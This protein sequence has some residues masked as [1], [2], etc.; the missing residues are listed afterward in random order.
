MNNC[1]YCVLRFTFDLLYRNCEILTQFF[2]QLLSIIEQWVELVCAKKI[3]IY[4]LSYVL[5]FNP[6]FYRQ[7]KPLHFYFRNVECFWETDFHAS[8]E[9]CHI[10]Y[11]F[12]TIRYC[13]LSLFEKKCITPNSV[14]WISE[15]HRFT[16]SIGLIGELRNRIILYQLIEL[17]I[18][19]MI[20]DEVYKCK[21][22]CIE[23]QFS[24][25]C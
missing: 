13:M 19:N 23:F 6:N 1:N 22:L 20:I 17:I 10:F 25:E 9:Y 12:A 11:L 21:I 15:I 18:C 24:F 4:R 7:F 16:T 2:Y 14:T 8:E 5:Q 3:F